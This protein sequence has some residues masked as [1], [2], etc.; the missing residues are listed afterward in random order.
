[1]SKCCIELREE[2]LEPALPFGPGPHHHVFATR[3]EIDYAEVVITEGGESVEIVISHGPKQ[4]DGLSEVGDIR[5]FAPTGTVQPACRR[6][7]H[8]GSKVWYG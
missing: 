5:P 7:R 4:L 2:S 8:G 3:V 6:H 1:M